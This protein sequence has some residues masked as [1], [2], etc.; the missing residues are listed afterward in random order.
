MFL[1]RNSKQ[2][3]NKIKITNFKTKDIPIRENGDNYYYIDNYEQATEKQCKEYDKLNQK[4]YEKY[5]NIY[6]NIK[7]KINDCPFKL[8]KEPSS[9]RTPNNYERLIK[10]R[11]MNESKNVT[12]QTIATL[13]VLSKGY[14]ISLDHHIDGLTPNDIIS[15]AEKKCKKDYNKMKEEAYKFLNKIKHQ[16]DT[17]LR[18]QKE[19]ERNI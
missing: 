12:N 19:K 17:E 1:R 10:W 8:D 16:Q 15:K 9:P 14:K 2:K 4:I 3:N 13:Y 7:M 11:L 6:N 18:L 5:T